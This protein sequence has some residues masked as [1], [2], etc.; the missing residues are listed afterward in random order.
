MNK[1]F[2]VQAVSQSVRLRWREGGRDGRKGG[3]G[4]GRVF[5]REL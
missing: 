3:H 4:G 2:N 1:T 5:T